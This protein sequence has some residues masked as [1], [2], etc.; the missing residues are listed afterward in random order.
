MIEPIRNSCWII[1]IY[2]VRHPPLEESSRKGSSQSEHPT[3]TAPSL[4]P[5]FLSKVL[6]N[7]IL[8]NFQLAPHSTGPFFKSNYCCQNRWPLVMANTGI[9]WIWWYHLNMVRSS[10]YGEIIST[11]RAR[12]VTAR[13]GAVQATDQKRRW[14]LTFELLKSKG[15]LPRWPCFWKR[16]SRTTGSRSL[17]L[18]L[19]FLLL[20]LSQSFSGFSSSNSSSGTMRTDTGTGRAD[21]VA[22]IAVFTLARSA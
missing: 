10:I 17:P 11:Q 14:K 9:I 21:D 18:W 4:S 20:P 1:N 2:N 13:D 5:S 7:Q 16:W 3:S 8:S 22:N 19:G 12:V 15:F 6:K